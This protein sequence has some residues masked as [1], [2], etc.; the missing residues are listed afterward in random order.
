VQVP[1]RLYQPG[2]VLLRET[3]VNGFFVTLTTF[4]MKSF[5]LSQAVFFLKF[6]QV[7]ILEYAVAADGSMIAARAG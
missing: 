4:S 3:A 1:P 2:I 5:E 7:V 6:S